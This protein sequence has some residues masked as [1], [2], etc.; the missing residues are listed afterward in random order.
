MFK[1]KELND[2]YEKRYL[3]EWSKVDA[4]VKKDNVKEIQKEYTNF[5]NKMEKYM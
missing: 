4:M 1:Y 3:K 5:K 2:K